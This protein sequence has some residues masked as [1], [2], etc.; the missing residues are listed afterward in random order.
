R[1]LALVA[2]ER[3]QHADAERLL[4]EAAAAHEQAGDRWQ[5][6]LILTMTAGHFAVGRGDDARALE[7]LRKALR[8]ARDSGSGERMI[9]AVE[10][11]AYV[12]HHR[13]RARE[14]ATLAGAAEAVF[15]RLPCKV[16]I[17]QLV[18]GTGAKLRRRPHLLLDTTFKDVASVVSAGFD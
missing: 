12:L 10:L 5:L 1:M 4:E 8:L 2:A 7:P 11:A 6:A 3:G 13:G 9:Y 16:D 18:S 14:A 17:I 15:L